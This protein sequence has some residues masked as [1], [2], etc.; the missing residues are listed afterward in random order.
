MQPRALWVVAHHLEVAASL[1]GT[2]MNLLRALADA[3]AGNE[4]LATS[5]RHALSFS[6]HLIALS[7]YQ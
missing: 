2:W 6:L 7:P 3:L 4:E 5:R 1:D